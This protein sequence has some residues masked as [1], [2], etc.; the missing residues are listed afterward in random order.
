M[1]VRLLSI[2]PATKT[3]KYRVGWKLIQF[4]LR[5]RWQKC[6]VRKICTIEEEIQQATFV[7][8]HIAH[9]T[10]MG[11]SDVHLINTVRSCVCTTIG[12]F[13][14][15]DKKK[16]K[17]RTTAYVYWY[18]LSLEVFRFSRFLERHQTRNLAIEKSVRKKTERGTKKTA[19]VLYATHAQLSCCVHNNIVM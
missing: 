14:R 2:R 12:G 13:V 1:S 8:T 19:L 5:A 16:K 18:K 11:S 3:I 17:V 7:L 15:K 10:S 4:H 6:Y 9:L